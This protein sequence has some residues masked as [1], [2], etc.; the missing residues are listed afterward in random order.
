MTRNDL[1]KWANEHHYPAFQ[2]R[3][4]TPVKL[5]PVRGLPNVI[6]SMKY[7]IGVE[8]SDNKLSWET[9]IL[10]GNDDMISGLLAYIDSLSPE[11]LANMR[12]PKA[13]RARERGIHFV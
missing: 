12:K 5:Y 2:F 1:L 8:G 11:Q 4:A 13:A 10:L 9:A 3:G 7:A 6:Q